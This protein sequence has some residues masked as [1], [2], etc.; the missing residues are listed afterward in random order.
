MNVRLTF[1]PP[2]AR[3][4]RTEACYPV[5]QSQ[6]QALHLPQSAI[7]IKR[8]EASPSPSLFFE[9]WFNS[10]LE[11]QEG[12]TWRFPLFAILLCR[13]GS[14]LEARMF[15][16][17]RAPQERCV[18]LWCSSKPGGVMIPPE[19]YELTNRFYSCGVLNASE[20]QVNTRY[21]QIAFRQISLALFL[22]KRFAELVRL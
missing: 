19:L 15:H 17:R 6:T 18:Q 1:L 21:P 22:M 7:A 8:R 12:G 20:E 4:S 10:R 2:F 16:G 14:A 11:T 13:L 5:R 9:T 3:C